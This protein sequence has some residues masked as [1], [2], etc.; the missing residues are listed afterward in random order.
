VDAWWDG[1]QNWPF[2]PLPL[3]EFRCEDWERYY[4]HPAN[5]LLGDTN[6]FGDEPYP[7]YVDPQFDMIDAEGHFYP[8]PQVYVLN[9]RNGRWAALD[10]METGV[11]GGV[12]QSVICVD[13]TSVYECVPTLGALPG[14]T[15]IAVYKDPSNHSDSCWIS[16]KVGIGGG[17]TPPSQ[18]SS[19]MFADETG[20]EV[21][22]YTDVDTVYVK[23]IDPS[24]AGAAALL[25]AVEIAG[26]TYDLAP[27]AGAT[28]DTFITDG[29]DLDLVAG[30]EL[31]ATY[32]DPTDPTD[33]SSDTVSVEASVLDVTG[34]TVTP[35]PFED[36]VTFGY[37]GSGVAEVFQVDV[38]DVAGDLVWSTE[39]AYVTEVTWDGAGAAKGA[40]IYIITVSDATQ[41]FSGR[42]VLVKK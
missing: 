15:I 17:G 5:Y 35:N 10:L 19:T 4:W 3:N 18:A 2:G 21:A 27:L 1:G 31:T 39:E 42:D 11:S 28:S 32:T 26:E 6:I 9:P 12:F 37:E 22:S 8:S 36:E 25:D 29:L 40:Y 34:F 14:D 20:A 16:I 13:L 41:T 7:F 24:H 38:Y 23:V 33:T 30:E